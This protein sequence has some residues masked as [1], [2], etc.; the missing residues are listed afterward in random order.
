MD[1]DWIR[2]HDHNP[3][4]L[5]PIL[6]SVLWRREDTNISLYTHLLEAI[7]QYAEMDDLYNTSEMA[8]ADFTEAL[9]VLGE[10]ARDTNPGFFWNRS[11]LTS[12]YNIFHTLRSTRNLQVNV[13]FTNYQGTLELAEDGD[14]LNITFYDPAT[15]EHIH[16][17]QLPQ[18][19]S[20]SKKLLKK[21]REKLF[22]A[23]LNNY[24]TRGLRT[25]DELL[26]LMTED[27]Q[28][29]YREMVIKYFET[30]RPEFRRVF[31]VLDD[32]R[33]ES[34]EDEDLPAPRIG[35]NIP[36][37]RRHPNLRGVPPGIEEALRHRR[38]ILYDDP[39]RKAQR[40]QQFQQLVGPD[41]PVDE[42]CGTANHPEAQARRI[43]RLAELRQ[44]GQQQNDWQIRRGLPQP[45]VMLVRGALMS[46]TI[47]KYN[48]IDKLQSGATRYIYQIF[49][50]TWL[51]CGY[52]HFHPRM[53]LCTAPVKVQS[54][55]DRFKWMT[56]GK[57]IIHKLIPRKPEEMSKVL[58]TL[59]RQT[60]Y[61][62]PDYI[63]KKYIGEFVMRVQIRSKIPKTPTVYVRILLLKSWSEERKV[64]IPEILSHILFQDPLKI[65]SG[66]K[67]NWRQNLRLC[68]LS[69]EWDKILRWSIN[70]HTFP[71]P[72]SES[73]NYPYILHKTERFYK[74]LN[75]GSRTVR[76]DPSSLAYKMYAVG[77]KGACDEF[78]VFLMDFAPDVQAQPYAAES[79]EAEDATAWRSQDYNTPNTNTKTKW[80]YDWIGPED[81]SAGRS[82]YRQ[83]TIEGAEIYVAEN[84]CEAILQVDCQLTAYPMVAIPTKSLL[85]KYFPWNWPKE[86]NYKQLTPE[87]KH[88]ILT[89]RTPWAISKD[90]KDIILDRQYKKVRINLTEIAGKPFMEFTPLVR[91]EQFVADAF[92]DR[93][94]RIIPL[95]TMTHPILYQPTT[96]SYN[97]GNGNIRRDFNGTWRISW[98]TE[99]PEL[100][101]SIQEVVNYTAR[102]LID[103]Y[104]E[105]HLSISALYTKG[106]QLLHNRMTTDEIEQW[107]AHSM[108][109]LRMLIDTNLEIYN[110]ARSSNWDKTLDYQTAAYNPTSG[111]VQPGQYASELS[112]E[113]GHVNSAAAAAAGIAAA[114]SISEMF[115]GTMGAAAAGIVT[116]S[117]LANIVKLAKDYWPKTAPRTTTQEEALEDRLTKP[118]KA[119]KTDESHSTELPTGFQNIQNLQRIGKIEVAYT[120]PT[121]FDIH[122]AKDPILLDGWWDQ[123][124]ST[125]LNDATWRIGPTAEDITEATLTLPRQILEEQQPEKV[126]KIKKS[127]ETAA[128]LSSDTQWT[129]IRTYDREGKPLE[130]KQ[131]PEE[132]LEK[133][134]EQELNVPLKPKEEKIYTET[135][136]SSTET[137]TPST[138]TTTESPT[139]DTPAGTIVENEWTKPLN[140]SYD[141][142][143]PNVYEAI[144]SDLKARSHYSGYQWFK[145]GWNYFRDF[146]P[147]IVF[148]HGDRYCDDD[149]NRKDKPWIERVSKDIYQ[150][151]GLE[152]NTYRVYLL[153]YTLDHIMKTDFD[154]IDSLNRV[155]YH[156]RRKHT[157]AKVASVL[158]GICHN[159]L[160]SLL[161]TTN[162]KAFIQGFCGAAN[163]M[164]WNC[165]SWA[166]I[167]Q[168]PYNKD[169]SVSSTYTAEY[170]DQADHDIMEAFGLSPSNHANSTSE[171]IEEAINSVEWV[172]T[173][174]FNYED[175]DDSID[176][177]DYLE[178]DEEEED[179]EEY[180]EEEE[181]QT[182]GQSGPLRQTQ[183]FTDAI[184][185]VTAF[186]TGTDLDPNIAYSG[187]ATS[188][189]DAG[190]RL[191]DS[192][193]SGSA[194]SDALYSVWSHAGV[195]T[196]NTQTLGILVAG[197]LLMGRAQTVAEIIAG[198]VSYFTE[199]EINITDW[200]TDALTD[201][202]T[203]VAPTLKEI[204][205]G[206]NS[207]DTISIED[208]T[209]ALNLIS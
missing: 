148:D 139:S 104:N 51:R 193:W 185:G 192:G 56:L 63:C 9:Y 49:P 60:V 53:T 19:R 20:D 34:S 117:A 150:T 12:L 76:E 32:D 138:Q 202:P 195:T 7:T 45:G 165:R 89:S 107:G 44:A 110:S 55:L 198:T 31:N 23:W 25:P 28:Q 136:T 196:N 206:L 22:N 80:C 54:W 188:S 164:G 15:N 26:N 27:Q 61:L 128:I 71:A 153:L 200:C 116:G 3:N 21:W 112:G 36:A 127:K 194:I 93:Q 37:G 142:I 33:D 77:S 159:S 29:K 118:N 171:D 147:T 146:Q 84:T 103:T 184:S 1:P 176:L 50:R 40:Y 11:N 16:V 8:Q 151:D 208:C 10:L 135:S 24:L 46:S 70:E 155:L 130:I 204:L 87:E 124:E 170:Y 85:R 203:N 52:I 120:F 13:P 38:R 47:Q 91:F 78:M 191:R 66:Y 68:A 96:N 74:R 131:K 167:V 17:G 39:G 73:G 65:N 141:A 145:E 105:S 149:R 42:M 41:D 121:V 95:Q 152:Y 133:K 83:G 122:S 94:G 207:Q 69:L 166:E 181:P 178:E 100:P 72:S 18:L 161:P 172:N 4:P 75:F 114:T 98:S 62:Y 113:S 57:D 30:H 14:S 119:S 174:R 134:V 59:D 88:L 182:A 2:T 111:A 82:S 163:R 177:D 162:Y 5:N 190:N 35:P 48:R 90:I 197:G 189:T 92:Y 109:A 180:E 99:A 125:F 97:V 173:D 156:N 205:E 143:T 144:R 101:E 179:N 140:P 183:T 157:T 67:E 81:H 186:V 79:H 132:K 129:T 199:E 154:I 108:T 168:R 123:V 201:Y 58:D 106:G 137:S 43:E 115:G 175:D 6:N 64:S 160:A 187:L 86:L 102:E 209:N 126:K 158:Q 169:D